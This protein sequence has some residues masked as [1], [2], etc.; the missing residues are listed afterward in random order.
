M[1]I[2]RLVAILALLVACWSC[3]TTSPSKTPA[4]PP[5]IY[6]VDS[7]GVSLPVPVKQVKPAYTP[8]ALRNR[9]Q[10][11]VLMSAIVLSDGTVGEV[12]VLRSLDTQFGLDESAIRATKQWLF[13]PGTR[14]GLAVAVRVTVELS[15][16]ISG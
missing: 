15:F 12:A 10:G 8:E 7:P 16:T 5:T 9:V 2:R 6:D 4:S 14:N 11:V 3:S 13:L 1:P